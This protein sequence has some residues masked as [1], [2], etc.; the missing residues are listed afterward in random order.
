[1]NDNTE[2]RAEL[3]TRTSRCSNLRA[4]NIGVPS[5]LWEPERCLCS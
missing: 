1:V 2:L 3:S 5:L 4:L